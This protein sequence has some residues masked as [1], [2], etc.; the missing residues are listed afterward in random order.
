MKTLRI[1]SEALRLRPP[2]ELHPQS[3]RDAG[4]NSPLPTSDRVLCGAL[5]LGPNMLLTS[6]SLSNCT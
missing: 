3:G 2:W 4:E 6:V 1:E 5:E